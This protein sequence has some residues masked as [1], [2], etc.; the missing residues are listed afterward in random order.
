MNSKSILI[1]IMATSTLANAKSIDI[2][3]SSST[4]F[5]QPFI[6]VDQKPKVS[7]NNENW[8]IDESNPLHF[9]YTEKFGNNIP[10]QVSDFYYTKTGTL[11][12]I[13]NS[14]PDSRDKIVHHIKIDPTTK[15]ASSRTECVKTTEGTQ[16]S[17]ASTSF[18]KYLRTSNVLR[19]GFIG[20]ARQCQ[21]SC[22]S[23]FQVLKTIPSRYIN[24]AMSEEEHNL[25]VLQKAG[26]VSDNPFSHV[27]SLAKDGKEI[28]EKLRSLINIAGLCRTHLVRKSQKELSQPLDLSNKEIKEYASPA[29][30][31]IQN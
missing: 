1:F 18:C 14:I 24:E 9:K 19:G 16:C 8:E 5:M 6:G 20:K 26:V 22:D 31:T 10:A 30:E 17:T 15:Y 23:T 3:L 25:N 4:L 29:Y 28:G 7:S 13:T 2:D 11:Q 12:G 27:K 21:A